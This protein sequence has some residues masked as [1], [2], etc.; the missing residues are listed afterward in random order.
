MG[1]GVRASLLFLLVMT[2]CGGVAVQ[3][4]ESQP[5][6]SGMETD[7]A[8]VKEAML[9]NWESIAPEVRPSKNRDGSLNAGRG[10]RNSRA[11]TGCSRTG[12][13]VRGSR[14]AVVDRIRIA[15]SDH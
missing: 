2:E 10:W 7:L 6:A 13:L 15:G 8:K 4:P 9:G 14:P 5:R 1:R 11:T 12:L 3:S